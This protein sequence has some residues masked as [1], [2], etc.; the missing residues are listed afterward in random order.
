[1]TN[2]IDVG[3][4]R[5]KRS[6]TKRRDEL[7]RRLQISHDHVAPIAGD[8]PADGMAAGLELAEREQFLSIRESLRQRLDDVNEALA[9][10]DD[11]TYGRCE[12]CGGV[13][14]F[15]RLAAR[16]EARFCVAH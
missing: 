5:A 11:G 9:R 14:P 13:I 8:L 16:P 2:T 12:T 6:L 15:E 3:L 1:M 10:L 7:A 4:E